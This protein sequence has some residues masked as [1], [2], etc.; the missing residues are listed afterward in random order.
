MDNIDT[1]HPLARLLSEL[2]RALDEDADGPAWTLAAGELAGLLP[3]IARVANRLDGVELRL[4]AQADRHG[5]GD[6]NGHA[7][8]AGWWANATRSAKPRA[9]RQVALARRLDQ[10]DCATGDA[11]AAGAVSRDQAAVI[12]EAVDAL[13]RELV[14]PALRARA[15]AHLVELAEHHHPRELRL[16]GRRI[17]EVIAPEIAEERERKLL[18]AEERDATATASLVMREDG[19]G[20]MRGRFKIP[21]LAGQMLAK[22]LAAIAAPRHRHAAAESE[23]GES[24]SGESGSGESASG[25]RVARPLRLGR[26]FAEYIETRSAAE[27]PEAGGVAA[28]VV[29]TMTLE[30]LIGDSEQAATLDLGDRISA[31]EARRLACEAGIIPAV[32]GAGSQ[33]LDLGRKARF[34]NAPQRIALALRDRGCAAEHCDWP[35]AMCH[36]HHLTPWSRGG[37]TSLMNGVLLCPRHHTLAHDARYQLKSGPG[38]RVVFSKRT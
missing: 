30:N 4:L 36:A 5:V 15:E 37:G 10:S 1:R 28:T 27:T 16:L 9:H 22:H 14:E 29:V 19:H 13:P 35:P 18:E 33:P 11:L 24:G 23:A 26:A 12:V 20:S 34:H 6:P 21:V 25:E 32:L 3:R 38:G 31:A 17:L 7:N 2:E 8:T